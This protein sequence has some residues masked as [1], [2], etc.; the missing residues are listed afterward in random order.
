MGHYK[1]VLAIYQHYVTRMVSS[2]QL[3]VDPVAYR[4]EPWLYWSVRVIPP[5]RASIDPSREDRNEL[6]NVESCIQ[7]HSDVVERKTGEPAEKIYR[8]IQRNRK[9][10][11]KY[12]LEVHMPNMGRDE[13]GE[14]SPTQPGDKN[15]ESSD[16]NSDRQ[17]VGA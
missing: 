2:G 4:A 1:A 15:Q 16:A 14:N 5:A 3:D 6:V 9:M 11:E 8:R 13:G 12:E 10:M 17:A 7:P